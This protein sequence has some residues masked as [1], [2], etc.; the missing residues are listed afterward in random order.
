M[1]SVYTVSQVTSY[2]RNNTGT[3][4]GVRGEIY[5]PHS[6]LATAIGHNYFKLKLK[7]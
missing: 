6:R 4:T 5:E 2:I 1:G 3:D 7:C